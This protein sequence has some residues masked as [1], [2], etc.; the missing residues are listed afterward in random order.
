RPLTSASATLGRVMTGSDGAAAFDPMR[1]DLR[2]VSLRPAVA[3]D[4]PFARAAHHSAYRDVIE[5]QFGSFDTPLQDGF[6][7]RAWANRGFVIVIHDDKQAGF[8]R[9]ERTPDAL[10]VHELV[11]LPTFQGAGLG[12]ELLRAAQKWTAARELPVTMQVLRENRA[13]RLYRRLGF[14]P[15]GESATHVSMRWPPS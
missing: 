7:A 15:C 2:R 13:A 14:Q 8:A 4:E 10:V 1:L 12:T 9:F 6:F 11:L 3:S 5:R